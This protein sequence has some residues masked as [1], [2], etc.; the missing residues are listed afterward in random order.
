M[1]PHLLEITLFCLV[2]YT[3]EPLISASENQSDGR[4]SFNEGWLYFLGKNEDARFPETNDEHWLPLNLPHAKTSGPPASRKNRLGQ[5]DTSL[6]CWY[7]KRFQLPN[8]QSNQPIQILFDGANGIVSVWINGHF[9]GRSSTGNDSFLF[10]L[11]PFVRFG[12]SDNVISV[13]LEALDKSIES[14]E[15]LSLN[16]NV[17]LNAGGA[18]QSHQSH[19]S[20]EY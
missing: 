1:R 17:W 6:V 5:Q 20:Q 9:L 7:R 11:D 15:Q 8:H 13:K 18:D 16:H 19:T 3:G 10:Q 2:A 12:D 4:D 14:P